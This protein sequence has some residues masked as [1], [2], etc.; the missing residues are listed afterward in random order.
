MGCISQPISQ[1]LAFE[2]KKVCVSLS[3]SLVWSCRQECP[4]ES[5]PSFW[6]NPFV[7]CRNIIPTIQGLEQTINKWFQNVNLK[8][9]FD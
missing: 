6:P 2:K 8:K 4:Q 1:V 5:L 9:G 7:G 3:V